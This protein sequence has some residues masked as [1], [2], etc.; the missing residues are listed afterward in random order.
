MGGE[1]PETCWAV[2]KRQ[3]NKMENCCIWLVIYL[4]CTMMHGLT[5][6]ID[7][8]YIMFISVVISYIMEIVFESSAC[9]SGLL[10]SVKIMFLLTQST[11]PLFFLRSV[12][13]CYSILCLEPDGMWKRSQ[14]CLVDDSYVEMVNIGLISS[15]A[16]LLYWFLEPWRWCLLKDYAEAHSDTWLLQDEWNNDC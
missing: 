4:N 6:L 14:S 15:V 12:L 11:E 9:E 13:Y 16:F 8:P 3:D 10:T 7:I 2:N 5:H 1:T